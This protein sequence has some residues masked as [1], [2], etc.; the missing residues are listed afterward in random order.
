MGSTYNYIDVELEVSVRKYEVDTKSLMKCLKDHKKMTCEQI[1]VLL[2]K[3]RTLVEHWFRQDKYFAV[4]DADIWYE[5]KALLGIQ[6]TEF[7][8]SVTTYETK[9]GN[10]DLR[11]RIYV[12]KIAPTL[13]R[14][15]ENNLY[16]LGDDTI[17]TT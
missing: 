4:P 10:Y 11:N 1:S 2:G 13:T 9:G 6:T 7:D 14:N 12:G 3:S 16:L 5:L 8:K 15:C 17:E